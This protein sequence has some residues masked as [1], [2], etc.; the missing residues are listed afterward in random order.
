VIAV[1][2]LREIDRSAGFSNRIL[3]QHLERHPGLDPRDR[4]LTT[5]L[6]YG[7]LR[8]RTRLDA[9]I[10]AHARRPTGLRGELREALRV[11]VFERLELGR[12]GAIVATETVKILEGLDA[13]GGLRG[14]VHAI[15][16]AVDRT[17]AEIDAKLEAA[18]PL[19]VL[20]RRWSVPRWLGGRW[21]KQ[22]GPE[23]AVHRARTLAEPPPVDL[24]VD[25]G[26]IDLD[27]ATRRL[28]TDHPSVNVRRVDWAPQALR[29]TGGGDLFYGPLHDAGLVSVQGLGAQQAAIMLDPEPGMRV[30]DACAG[31]GVKT[32]QLAELMHRRGSIV[33][34][35]ADPRQLRSIAQMH[36]RGALPNTALELRTVCADLTA[37]TP[38]LGAAPFDAILLD[39]PCTGLGNL[40]RHPEIRWHRRYEDIAVRRE[41][42]RRLL[43]RTL[44]RL[45][46]GATMVYAACTTEPEEG[47]EVVRSTLTDSVAELTLEQTLTPEHDGT[48]G[49]YVARLR[50]V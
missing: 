14:V 41:L 15:L 36:A 28:Q 31:M 34:A 27:E 49:F 50:R 39:V 44:T 32:L 29:T 2:V 6:V 20:E 7:V 11:G 13:S 4:G 37:E 22:L 24:R 1:R 48:E 40:A 21:L 18:P 16:G 26:R 42:Q 30:L 25:L 45:R 9:H 35:D 3:S 43:L 17:A 5:T 8:Q 10:D 19:D 12:P 47:S 23:R 33:A 38:E 46:P